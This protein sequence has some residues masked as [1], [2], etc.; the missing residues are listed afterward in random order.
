MAE[1]EDIHKIPLRKEWLK[2]PSY[3]R[4][5]K[6]IA[7]IKKYLKKHYRN[8]KIKLGKYLNLEIWKRGNK[9]PPAYI[10]VKV[11]KDKDFINVELPGAPVEE[12]SKKEEKKGLAAKLKE[13]VITKEE[14]DKKEEEKKEVKELEKKEEKILEE[15][16]QKRPD[17]PRGKLRD[18]K[19]NTK[20]RRETII[21]KRDKKGPTQ[22]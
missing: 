21:T 9:N 13:K 22:K 15:K 3:R 1:K 5:K 12:A 7:G 10:T 6:A 20:I 14:T 18:E 16:F 4:S 19:Q 17:I 8:Q 2:A 11:I